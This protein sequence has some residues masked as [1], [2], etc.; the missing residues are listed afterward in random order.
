MNL[1][2]SDQPGEIKA[3]EEGQAKAVAEAEKVGEVE[4]KTPQE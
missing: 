1:A 2:L 3:L 4:V